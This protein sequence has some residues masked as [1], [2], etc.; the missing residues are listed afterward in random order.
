MLDKLKRGHIK[1]AF[2]LFTIGLLALLPC[3]AWYSW[4]IPTWGD[5]GIINGIVAGGSGIMDTLSIVWQTTISL[6]PELF[7]NYGSVLFLLFGV[8]L[9]LTERKKYLPI[10]HAYLWVLVAFLAYYFYEINMIT[11]VHD[12]YLF[13]FLPLL[14][15]A[16]GYG[17]RSALKSK[18]FIRV[19]SILLLLIL[20]LTAFLRADSRWRI[21]GTQ[22]LVNDDLEALKLATPENAICIVGNDLSGH[23][24]LYLL[25]RRGM[26][27]SDDSLPELQMEWMVAN[28][29]EFMYSSSLK[30][31]NDP[32]IRP[33]LKELILDAGTMR[34]Y[35]LIEP[36]K[37]S[38][39][40]V[41]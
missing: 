8:Y 6:I 40:W 18:T 19:L 31:E 35:K 38:G 33:Y 25:D 9:F 2:S 14:F 32:A 26:S 17:L 3:V 41:E 28:G 29:S 11:T 27:F 36:H 37:N 23:I 20:P 16:V 1:T 34:V 4:V 7:V 15:L 21:E 22:A 39:S 10:H 13:P 5:A 12:Y 30:V 24:L